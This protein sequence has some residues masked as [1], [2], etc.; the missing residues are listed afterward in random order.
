[1][2][3]PYDSHKN[4]GVSKFDIGNAPARSRLGRF[5]VSNGTSYWI[6][7]LVQLAIPHFIS[8]HIPVVVMTW[9]FPLGLTISK[10]SISG[11]RMRICVKCLSNL[12]PKGIW[13]FC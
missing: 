13:L 12:G 4:H 10:F 8:D 5:L 9:D 11:V 1:M 3:A 2:K 7:N 6:S